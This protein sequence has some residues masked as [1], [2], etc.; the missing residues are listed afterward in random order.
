M[1]AAMEG[2]GGV[3]GVVRGQG[4]SVAELIAPVR[5]SVRLT[6]EQIAVIEG[7]TDPMLVIAGAGS[8]KT[9][10]L[11]FRFLYLLDHARRLF[12][13]DLAPDEI[14]CLTFTKKAAGEIANR[15]ERHIGQVFGPDP[16]RPLASV[17]TYH[18]YAASLV[19]EHGLRVGLDPDAVVM[20]DAALWQL[21]ARLVEG[22]E[23]EFAF[24][25]SP[26]TASAAV[27]ALAA[28]LAEHGRTPADL[29]DLLLAIVARIHE[30]P[31]G[32]RQRSEAKRAALAGPFRDR[33]AL[34]GIVEEFAR[35]KQAVGALDFSDQI[36]RANDVALLPVV[37]GL[38][39]SR[40]RAVLLDEFQDTS[41]NQ[42]DLFRSL[43]GAG[44]AVAAVGDPHQA[45]YGFR[46]ASQAALSRF[47]EAFRV[48][49][50]RTLSLSVSWRNSEAILRAA[51][52]VTAPLRAASHLSVPLL[53]S[54]SEATEESETHR[55]G[56]AISAMVFA[57]DAAEA[58]G[59]VSQVLARREALEAARVGNEAAHVGDEAAHVAD[60]AV[61]TA[62]LCR[63]RRFFPAV[64]E[65]LRDAGVD[66]QVVG[67]GG[68]LDTPA[69]VDLVALLQVAH[70]P[71]RGDSLMRLLTSERVALGIRDLAA[72]GEWSE[73]LAGPREERTVDASIVEAIDSPP[74]LDWV[75]RDGRT[76]SEPARSRLADLHV[77]VETIR[78]HAYLPLTELLGFAARA[79]NLDIESRVASHSACRGGGAEELD[80]LLEAARGFAGGVEHATLG[81]FLAWLDAAREQERGLEAPLEAA[82]PGAVQ[83]LTVHAAK[84]REWDVVGIPGLVDGIFPSCDVSGDPDDPVYRSGGWLVGVD[85]LPWPLRRDRAD[86]PEWAWEAP[87]NLKEFEESQDRF[88]EDAGHYLAE[89]EERRL[90]YVA[91]T[92][93]RTD[94]VL[95]AVPHPESKPPRPVS[96]YV[97]ELAGAGLVDLLADDPV[98]QYG[99]PEPEPGTEGDGGNRDE[100][101]GDEEKGEEAKGD[102]AAAARPDATWPAPLTQSQIARRALAQEVRRAMTAATPPD[103]LAI[104]YGSELSA[105]LDE[106]R[107]PP[108]S[109]LT[110]AFPPHLSSTAMV[111]MA[112]DR[113][114][115]AASLRRPIPVEPTS[116]ARRGSAFHAWVEGYFNRPALLDFDAWEDEGLPGGPAM[117]LE[118]G[119]NVLREAFLA[120]EWAARHPEA[121]EV[122]VEIPIAGITIR[123]RIDAV[124][125]AGDGL[126]RVTVVDW[127]TG[128]PP[129]EESD[130]VAR[131]VQLGTYRLAWARWK[132]LPLEEVDAVFFYPA[133]GQTVRPSSLADET[134]IVALI[135]GAG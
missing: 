9:Q 41:P 89:Q 33:A 8:G 88:R 42:L 39:R 85:K 74:D 82:R 105:L 93:A 114:A 38:E 75:S 116:A 32:P 64:V 130:R 63:A 26:G 119:V 132:G 34:A 131:E 109:H 12:G 134:S 1:T 68:L 94:V 22:W 100:R 106:M 101:R 54:R 115:F 16:D 60:K 59:L 72:L 56:P 76:L 52:A 123:S 31:L 118:G 18:A 10:T 97:R 40:F 47:V 44:H 91:L 21:S 96:R 107:E 25:G 6:A 90:F 46:G 35:V 124:F 113:D 120:S 126:D 135:A 110:V 104:P 84:G 65:A 45:I 112:R 58:H 13:R 80:G 108:S 102:D 24:E 30:L 66:F 95:T 27:P 15:V 5:P 37:Q 81:A 29:R 67:L 122:D 28:A 62:I 50:E 73:E 20:T 129:V 133:T 71:S 2:D 70:D 99:E 77:T 36:A 61:E 55:I 7:G 86:L 92:R 79:W 98:S 121:V 14:L 128:R 49:P 48:A 17:S 125:P 4:R 23:G 19:A 111:A 57:D 83:V 11:S 43:F 117:E 3:V 127:K 103:P 53:R 51:N 87:S 69:I 78:S